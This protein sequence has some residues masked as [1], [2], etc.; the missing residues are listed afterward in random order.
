M[1][2][3]EPRRAP[4]GGWYYKFNI[5]RSGE[6]YPS[7]TYGESLGKLVE[8]TRKTMQ[9]N[10]QEVPQNLEQIIEDQICER[11]PADRC[12]TGAGDY[13]ATAIHSAA[14]VVDR[15]FKTNLE[16]K[17]K[18]CLSCRKRRQALNKLFNN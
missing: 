5:E 16:Q 12:W 3:K 14:K 17:A 6:S 15:V 11:Q 2:L 1:K 13:V 8:N 4:V 9:V 10:G 18:G 7:T